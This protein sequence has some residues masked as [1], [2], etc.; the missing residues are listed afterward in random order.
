[1]CATFDALDNQG[2]LGLNRQK[3]DPSRWSEFAQAP[4]DNAGCQKLSEAVNT[5]YSECSAAKGSAAVVGEACTGFG[6]PCGDMYANLNKFCTVKADLT[7][8]SGGNWILKANFVPVPSDI[9]KET[10]SKTDKAKCKNCSTGRE[11]RKAK[12]TAT[13]NSD[14]HGLPPNPCR[15]GKCESNTARGSNLDRFGL[16]PTYVDTSTSQA[17][18]RTTSRSAGTKGTAAAGTKMK[19]I[20]QKDAPP[21]PQAGSGPSGGIKASAPSGGIGAS[22]PDKIK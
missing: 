1:M 5:C 9:R 13:S 6:L 20:I 15:D 14:T 12:R 2:C 11:T 10:Y 16:G 3:L 7:S 18:T 21:P 8:P 22:V 17:G 4:A 19:P